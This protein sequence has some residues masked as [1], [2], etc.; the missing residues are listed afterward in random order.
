MSWR[1]ALGVLAGSQPYF[2]SGESSRQGKAGA[3]WETAF[4]LLR[5]LPSP[6][7][8]PS[9][10]GVSTRRIPPRSAFWKSL[11]VGY[12]APR[13]VPLSSGRAG[14]TT[15]GLQ[16]RA[17]PGEVLREVPGDCRAPGRLAGRRRTPEAPLRGRR[18]FSRR[19]TT[20]LLARERR[21][22]Q[23]SRSERGA[24]AEGPKSP[25]EQGRRHLVVN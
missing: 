12:P 25:S 19:E 24:R 14:L 21:A 23:P 15:R 2:S 7:S 22:R 5:P 16:G 13:A 9:F 1:D 4:P 18:R 3:L 20:R 10:W 11:R 6:R 8:T 17:C